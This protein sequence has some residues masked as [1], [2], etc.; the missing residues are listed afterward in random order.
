[1]L[2]MQS[3]TTTK[4]A[5][6]DWKKSPKI[7]MMMMMIIAVNQQYPNYNIASNGKLFISEI[8][9]DC[10]S[11]FHFIAGSSNELNIVK[12]E[13]RSLLADAD[14]AAEMQMRS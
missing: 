4:A 9:T 12:E 10:L 5:L 2:V 11:N 14:T 13:L 3:V 6:A 1:M 8:G 7:W